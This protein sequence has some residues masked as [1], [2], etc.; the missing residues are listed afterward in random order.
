MGQ[1]NMVP[2]IVKYWNYGIIISKTR[3][4]EYSFKPNRMAGN[5]ALQMKAYYTVDKA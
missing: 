3:Q 4:S 1:K 5:N 2:E